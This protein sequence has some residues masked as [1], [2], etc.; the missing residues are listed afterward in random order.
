MWRRVVFRSPQKILTQVFSGMS[1]HVPGGKWIGGRSADSPLKCAHLAIPFDE[2]DSTP[3]KVQMICTMLSQ[4]KRIG[5]NHLPMYKYTEY[6]SFVPFI[7][8]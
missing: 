6:M 5:I 3:E 1:S 4:Y 2:L 7:C 8:T